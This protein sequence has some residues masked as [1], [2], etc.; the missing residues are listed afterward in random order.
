MEVPSGGRKTNLVSRYFIRFMET[1]KQGDGK[2]RPHPDASDST[3]GEKRLYWCSSTGIR[4]VWCIAS[5]FLKQCP[6][7]V[8]YGSEEAQKARK[9]GK[10]KKVSQR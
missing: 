3:N 4:K 5:S 9:N 6:Y 2:S 7:N 1:L 8:F 10:K